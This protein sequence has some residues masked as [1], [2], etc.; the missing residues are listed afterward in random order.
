MTYDDIDYRIA[1][2]AAPISPTLCKEKSTHAKAIELALSLLESAKLQRVKSLSPHDYG[3]FLKKYSLEGKDT[4]S[5]YD[6][7][8][9]LMGDLAHAFDQAQL[10]RLWLSTPTLPC[11][12]RLYES[13]RDLP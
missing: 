7:V 4:I 8:A 6:G 11:R 5:F 9:L 1:T 2:L 10:F 13:T 3:E 12:P